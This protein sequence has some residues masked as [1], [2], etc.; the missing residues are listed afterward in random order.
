MTDSLA[1]RSLFAGT[2]AVAY[3]NTA[4]EGLAPAAFA[5][6]LASYARDKALGSDGRTRMYAVEQR[7]RE[8]GAALL[9]A[10]P[11]EVAFVTSCAR[12]VNAALSAVRFERGDVLVTT[13]LEFPT[14][15]LAAVRLRDSGVEVRIARSAGGGVSAD[16][17]TALLDGRVR[18]VV[19]SLVSFKTG[20]LLDLAPVSAACRAAGALLVVDATQALGVVPVEAALAD[21]VV[22]SG[23]KWLLGAHGVAVLYVR[24]GAV[25]G[26][27][28][29]AVGWRSIVDP[30]ADI[31]AT[32]VDL[33]PDARRFEEGMP[34]F[35]SLYALDAGLELLAQCDPGEVAAHVRALGGRLRDEL[36]ARGLA[37]LGPAAEAERAG[38][39]AIADDRA[40]EHTAAL[41][42]RG[43]VVWGRDGRLRASVHL[44]NDSSDIDRLLEALPP[45]M[46]LRR[47][48]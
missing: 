48:A 23:F 35:P 43:V 20:A 9:G 38:I 4:A 2:D 30:F 1:P 28:P 31:L 6:A 7:C 27:E 29:E 10:D 21:V 42:E 46:L 36:A 41:R 45:T 3:L 25:G 15:D 8:R 47:S 5:E 34:P 11:A 26:L 24:A 22:A 37:P 33:A 40:E 16:A 19:V 17:I 18:A 32:G 12:G 39:V 14:T 44:Y 13:D